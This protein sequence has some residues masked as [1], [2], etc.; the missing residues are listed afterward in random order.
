VKTS[1]F[2]NPTY[3]PAL[4]GEPREQFLRLKTKVDVDHA[5]HFLQQDLWNPNLLFT[6]KDWETT[7][8]NNSLIVQL[9]KETKDATE[10]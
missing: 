2:P 10:D 5:G 1:L 3:L 7:L 9:L 8:N 4:I 6:E